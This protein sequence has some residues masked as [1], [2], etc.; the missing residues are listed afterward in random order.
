LAFSLA[1]SALGEPLPFR[2]ALDIQDVTATAS[3][4]RVRGVVSDDT[5][6]GFDGL[7]ARTNDVLAC[8]SRL[9][10]VDLYVI[11]SIGTQT[12]SW[13]DCIVAYSGTGTAARVGAPTFGEALLT[14]GVGTNAIPLTQ[15]V[16]PSGPSPYLKDA[17]AAIALHRIAEELARL[18]ALPDGT[19]SAADRARANHTGYQAR[20]TITNLTG[21]TWPRSSVTNLSGLTLPRANIT[22]LT[23]QTW[24]DGAVT[25]GVR[26]VKLDMNNKGIT[27]AQS[28]ALQ[29]GGYIK[30]LGGV[31]IFYT[32]GGFATF[33]V[34]AAGGK[35]YDRAGS[36]IWSA[37]AGP[38]SATMSGRWSA[39]NTQATANQIANSA[40]DRARANHTGNTPAGSVTGTLAAA[41][42]TASVT[43]AEP[44]SITTAMLQAKAVTGAK[45]GTTNN[46]T[47]GYVLK[48]SA[49]S[50][51][52]TYWSAD[53]TGAGAFTNTI[54]TSYSAG[55]SNATEL[56]STKWTREALRAATPG[57]FGVTIF[58]GSRPGMVLSSAFPTIILSAE[59]I[60][61]GNINNTGTGNI[62]APVGLM[63]FSG[64]LN[65][66]NLESGKLYLVRLYKN[67]A[68][69]LYDLGRML[70]PAALTGQWGLPICGAWYNDSATNIYT[71]RGYS[72]A[73]TSLTATNIA[74][75]ITVVPQ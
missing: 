32:E 22:N 56:A 38:L 9:G 66:V 5:Y 12:A 25:G 70:G 27:N 3:C 34:S 42:L 1:V 74:C 50:A 57:T 7:D 59:Q 46:P 71:L 65:L 10:D 6:A 44:A 45:L 30:V 48:S 68:T 54:D 61:S 58:R 64:I 33:G 69:T 13:L 26:G 47:A 2:A 51:S 72:T 49:G 39:T 20:S 60:D 43:N 35:L 75:G 16:G 67:G 53:Q 41:T 24:G 73:V 28:V 19:N 14:R 63:T 36:E 23:G 17:L 31:T 55:D 21:Q 11:Q 29:G 18:A 8:E 15:Y 40:S 37:G 4:W 62:V 52:N